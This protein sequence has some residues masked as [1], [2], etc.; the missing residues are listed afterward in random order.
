MLYPPV[1]L[2]SLWKYLRKLCQCGINKYVHM[3]PSSYILNHACGTAFDLSKAK[4]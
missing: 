1:S 3:Q 4:S 2:G